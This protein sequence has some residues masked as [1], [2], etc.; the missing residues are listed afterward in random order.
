MAAESGGDLAPENSYEEAVRAVPQ[1]LLR[2]GVWTAD[3]PE[4][5]ALVTALATAISNEGRFEG[6]DALQRLSAEGNGRPAWQR[7]A[8]FEGVKPSSRAAQPAAIAA[9]PRDAATAAVIEQ[10]RATYAV[11]AACHQ[12][13]GRGPPR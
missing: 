1:E 5:R 11:C 7:E 10:G 3:R 12:A 6:I 4:H 2:S 8:V 9:P 13:N